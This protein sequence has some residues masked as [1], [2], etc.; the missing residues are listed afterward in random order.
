[1]LGFIKEELPDFFAATKKPNTLGAAGDDSKKGSTSQL[2][3][4]REEEQATTIEKGAGLPTNYDLNPAF[5]A[6]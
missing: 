2:N 4:A 1:M 5:L 3:A 6:H